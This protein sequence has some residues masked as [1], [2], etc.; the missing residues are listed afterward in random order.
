MPV[1]LPAPLRPGDRIGVTSPS[2]GVPQ[3]LWPRFE[4][5]VRCLRD[6]GYDVV[7]GECMDGERHRQRTEGAACGRAHRHARRPGHPRRRTALGRR[8]RDRP[9]RPAR[10]GHPCGGGAHLARR[11]QRHHH[12]D[13]AL[14]APARLGDPARVEPDGHAVRPARGAAA[15]DRPR[16]RDR[17][18]ITQRGI[19]R[20]R[21]RVFDDWV[22]DPTLSTLELDGAGDWSLLDPANGPVDVTGRLVGG[23]LEVLGPICSTYA[24]VAAFGREHAA[25]GLSST[26]RRPRRKRSPPAGCC[27]RCGTPAGSTTRAP[28]SSGAPWPPTPRDDP[29][30]RRPRRARRSRRAR[31]PRRGVRPRRA[32]PAAGQR[33][34]GARR[35]GRRTARDQPRTS[36]R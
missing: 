31:G 3:R 23:C 12:L 11:L 36:A 4:H 1:V 28:S 19:G 14:H 2:S 8:H 22:D 30:R 33:I 35:H 13:A 24:D 6:R 34:A 27:T 10:L 21:T 29:A 26:S 18:P 9:P 5:A 32:V 25:E 20:H 16:G 15:L 17:A 7:V